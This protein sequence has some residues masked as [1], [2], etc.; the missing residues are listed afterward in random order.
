VAREPRILRELLHATAE[1]LDG[2]AVAPQLGDTP[3]EPEQSVRA[4]RIV[5]MRID[6]RL[7]RGEPRLALGADRG[8]QGRTVQGLAE[9][10]DRLDGRRLVRRGDLSAREE[11]PVGHQRRQ[12]RRLGRR[13]RVAGHESEAAEEEEEA[14]HRRTS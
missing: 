2:I 4:L 6:R 3:A 13:S 7:R 1:D 10:G 8:R 14:S 11:R 5:R 12:R 9:Q